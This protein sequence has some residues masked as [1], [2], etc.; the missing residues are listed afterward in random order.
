MD[1]NKLPKNILW[2][3]LGSQ[4]KRP[5]RNQDGLTGWRKTQGNWVVEF[6]L[7]LSRIEVAGDIWLRRPKPTQ[8]SRADN[9]EAW[10][11]WDPLSS[12]LLLTLLYHTPYYIRGG[13]DKSLARPNSHCRR[14]ESIVSLEREVCSCAEL[15]VFL[16]T[17]AER[18]HVKRRERFQQHG[19]A[20]CHQDFFSCK[21]RRRRK[22]TPFW[23]K[24]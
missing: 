16:V 9:D 14:T 23:Q 12:L 3:N 1:K 24:R 7:R 18:K 22:F 19:D 6:G 21:A 20:S 8:G 15:Q 5:D 13:A 11:F 4:R 2:T 17:E 10:Q